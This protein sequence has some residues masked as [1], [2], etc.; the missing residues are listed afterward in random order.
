MVHH[1]VIGIESPGAAFEH[2]LCLVRQSAIIVC[3]Y[4]QLV[5]RHSVGIEVQ[6]KDT[7]TW[8]LSGTVMLNSLST[9]CVVFKG[10]SNANIGCE[11]EEVFN[12]SPEG[13]DDAGVCVL[14]CYA[15][16][17]QNPGAVGVAH[18][19]NAWAT[20]NGVMGA[21]PTEIMQNIKSCFNCQLIVIFYYSFGII[22]K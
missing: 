9:M 8:P 12:S 2:K 3:A 4:L 15:L 19:N 17:G 6:V 16:K 14:L 18:R 10:G 13:E 21:S 22:N 7:F 20:P 11:R 5:Y 1:R